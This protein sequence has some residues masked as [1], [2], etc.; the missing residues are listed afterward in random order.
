MSSTGQDVLE[1]KLNVAGIQSRRLNK[2]QVVLA[3]SDSQFPSLSAF[4]PRTA[5]GGR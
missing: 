1:C 5:S 4:D 2:R 3:C